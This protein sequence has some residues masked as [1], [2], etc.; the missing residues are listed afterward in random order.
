MEAIDRLSSDG[1][2]G[3]K[4]R[5]VEIAS[6]LFSE[7]SYLGV[8]MGDIAERIGISKPALYYHFRSKMQIYSEVLDDVVTELRVRIAEAARAECP[9]ERLHQLVKSYLEFGMREKNIINALVLRLS[10][11]D[12]QLRMRIL[13]FRE[14]LLDQAQPI[15]EQTV[16]DRC[17]PEGTDSAC[18]TEMLMALMDGLLIE[19][20]FLGKTVDPE[21]VADQ[22]LAV[23]AL[24]GDEPASE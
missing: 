20:S 13:S 17:L 3:T 23:L 18:V 22:I 15:V 6:G 8:S 16:A 21:K 4:R 14:E 10:P 12:A 24:H 9:R 1:L 7:R 2:E 19:Y 11:D 5:I